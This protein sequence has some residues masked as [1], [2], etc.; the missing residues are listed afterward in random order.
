[1][2]LR[3]SV[4]KLC[5]VLAFILG[6]TTTIFAQSSLQFGVKAGLNFSNLSGGPH[7]LSARTGLF[8]GFDLNYSADSWPVDI[9]TG[10]YYSQKGAEGRYKE[11]IIK[12]DYEGNAGTFKLD[13][14]E[15]PVLAKYGF[16]TESAF[17]PYLLAGPYLDINLNSEVKAS[18]NIAYIEDISAEIKKTGF[19]A[20]IGAGGDFEISNRNFNIQARYGL[21]LSAVYED[22]SDEGEKHRVFTIVAGFVF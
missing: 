16:G 9:E 3:K 18:K 2:G 5:L 4:K 15:I 12:G 10:I 17:R 13:Y 21:G 19:G 20:I 14:L 6:I 1:M 7:E 8:A 22:R 11:A